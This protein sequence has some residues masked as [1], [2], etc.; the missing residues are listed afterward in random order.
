MMKK[1]FIWP[2]NLICISELPTPSALSCVCM[3]VCVLN[4][5]NSLMYCLVVLPGFFF[6]EKTNYL[7]FVKL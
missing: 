5:S 2:S 1:I 3:C 7:L 6:K 4:K